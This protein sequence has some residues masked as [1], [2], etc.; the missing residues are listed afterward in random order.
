MKVWKSILSGSCFVL[1][2][3]TALAQNFASI[4]P[5]P[6]QTEWQDKEIGVA[7]Q[8]GLNT[9]TNK[10]IGDGMVSPGVFNPS[11][12][13]ANQWIMAA[14]SVG[15]KYVIFV[16]KHH[17]GFCLWPSR[18]TDY[19]VRSSPWKT[20]KGDVVKEVSDACHKY[21]LK[22]GIYLSPFDAHERSYRFIS[23]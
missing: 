4:Q 14:K 11:H 22:F 21:G 12:L 17:D 2:F 13:D 9:F 15:A 3:S 10:E 1:F 19:S 23:P 16:A 5:S 7:I 8:F 20:G 18:T 6:Q